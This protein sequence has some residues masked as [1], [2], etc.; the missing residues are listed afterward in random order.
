MESK[1]FFP[2]HFFV[3]PILTRMRYGKNSAVA[4]GKKV[5]WA[6]LAFTGTVG[7][8]WQDRSLTPRGKDKFKNELRFLQVLL[9]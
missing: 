8:K 3:R 2:S 6:E 5:I 7:A 1:L 9:I 4:C